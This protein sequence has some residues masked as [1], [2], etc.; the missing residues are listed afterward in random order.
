MQR[1]RPLTLVAHPGED[2]PRPRPHPPRIPACD[3]ALPH[4]V[5]DRSHC[6]VC[7]RHHG[8]RG[9]RSFDRTRRSSTCRAAGRR[10][11]SATGP[12]QG[13]ASDPSR[14][15]VEASMRGPGGMVGS[16]LATLDRCAPTAGWTGA[17]AS[18]GSRA[19]SEQRRALG[20]RRD[21]DPGRGPIR[22]RSRDRHRRRDGSQSLSARCRTIRV[23][24]P[25]SQMGGA[26]RR[27]VGERSQRSY[28]RVVRD[29]EERDGSANRFGRDISEF[30]IV[31]EPRFFE[32]EV[33]HLLIQRPRDVEPLPLLAAK[34]AELL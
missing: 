32:H 20:K 15:R 31:F 9:R 16:H 21:D 14:L 13:L 34:A 11:F 7:E 17:V 29:E 24:G 8:P 3:L 23:L 28:G 22:G 6:P 1:R 30:L 12:G 5:P 18:S 10:G 4:G 19:A 25:G 33:H 2:R 27:H 26:P